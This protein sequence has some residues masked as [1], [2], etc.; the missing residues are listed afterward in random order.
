MSPP[1][2]LSLA[3]AVRWTS[4][5]AAGAAVVLNPVGTRNRP[6]ER[7]ERRPTR[8]GGFLEGSSEPADPRIHRAVAGAHVRVLASE[9]RGR[10]QGCGEGA[11]DRET[12]AESQRELE[13]E[14]GREV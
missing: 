4:R 9:K 13:R 14:D 12:E 8:L 1:S 2:A 10:A 6:S 11:E 7:A 5:A 3:A